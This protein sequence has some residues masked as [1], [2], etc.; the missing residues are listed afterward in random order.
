LVELPHDPDGLVCAKFVKLALTS[1]SHYLTHADWGCH[2]GVHSGWFILEAGSKDEARSV[3]PP[4]LRPQAK[5]VALNYFTLEEIERVFGD[6]L[7]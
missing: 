5:I 1:G 2:D 7:T 3:L 4:P 6:H